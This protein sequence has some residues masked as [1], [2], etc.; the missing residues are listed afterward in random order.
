MSTL[1][2]YNIGLDIGT[3]S[4]GWAVVEAGTQKIIRKGREK[5]TKRLWGVRLFDSANTAA[6]R[7]EAR[8]TRRRYERRRERIRLLQGE[9]SDEILKVDPNFYVRLKETFYKKKDIQNKKHPFSEEEK[10]IIKKEYLNKYKT[11]YHLRK[12]LMETDKKFDI[13]LVYLAI[14]HIIKYRGNFLYSNDNFNVNDLDI[15]S[16]IKD[17]FDAFEI[18]F[19]LISIEKL[20][21]GILNESYND[22]KIIIKDI[23]DV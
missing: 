6:E 7:R 5:D 21:N 14:H 3:N 13:R 18:D 20:K 22:R 9:F 12:D 10:N 2:K 17:I 19:S 23:Y 16:K 1:K 4:V 8:S 11:I 15:E